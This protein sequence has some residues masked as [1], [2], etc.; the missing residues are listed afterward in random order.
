MI[1]DIEKVWPEWKV[2]K[3]IGKGSFG[4][5]YKAVR[6]DHSLTTEAAIK[7][8][9][10]PQD[11][12]EVD[13]LRSDGMDMNATRTYL[14]GIVD[15]FVNEIQLM[16]SF[17]GIQNIVS[18]EDYKVVERTYEIGWDIFIR[19]E[20][21]TP[22][23]TWVID[24]PMSEADVIRLGIDMC[25]ALEICEK[26]QIIHRDIKP[27]NI[28]INDFGFFKLGDFGIARKLEGT[29][30]GLST[31]GTYNYM[32]P[33][34]ANGSSYDA[35]V[36]IYS[37]GIVLYRLLNSNRLP[38][39]D[40]DQQLMSPAARKEAIERRMRGEALPPPKNASKIMAGLIL[41][42]CAYDPNKRFKNASVMKAAL[43][44]V[45]NNAPAATPRMQ[46]A[47]KTAA[48]P[49]TNATERVVPQHKA[50]GP[51][52]KTVVIPEE[53]RTENTADKKKSKRKEKK[54]GGFV[55]KLIL[56]LVLIA[57]AACAVCFFVPSVSEN[58]IKSSENVPIIGTAIKDASSAAVRE[59]DITQILASA[60]DYA[61]AEDYEK[62]L[63][64]IAAGLAVYPDSNELLAKQNE[65]QT[66]NAAHLKASTLEQ[67]DEYA[68]AGDYKSAL[69][70]IQLAQSKGTTD[71]DYIQ[72]TAEY[73][74]ALKNAALETAKQQE[75][76]GDYLNAYQTIKDAL[77]I[78]GSDTALNV[79]LTLYEQYYVDAVVA[80]ANE[81]I[82]A[83][84]YSGARTILNAA[85]KNLPDNATLTSKLDEISASEPVSLSTF[86][87]ING[88]FEFNNTVPED[89][90][91]NDYS[92][93]VNYVVLGRYNGGDYAEVRV[94]GEYSSITMNVAP[95]KDIGEDATGYVQIYADDVLV[96]TS[97]VITRKTDAVSVS[98][99]ISGA[100]YIKIV[101]QKDYYGSIILSNILLWPN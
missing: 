61:A 50:A 66:E 74:E 94:Y 46:A 2:E 64:E 91:G 63:S 96:Q 44:N 52:Q 42:A 48:R 53:A 93:A 97:P 99:N 34:V 38:F 86:T 67:A 11:T 13:S 36:D 87:A 72:K 80:Q 68:S 19:M 65:Y 24:H 77:D 5:V 23:N 4:V 79:R 73:T 3:Q 54:K 26:R 43:Q 22:F 17:K 10:I 78:V 83:K 8:I 29:Q 25:T 85:I 100:D 101:V 27:E 35:R 41:C 95:Y 62:A 92:D 49:T 20:L 45:A 15:D 82:S 39:I 40:T 58:L 18:V 21:L 84:D 90:F 7:V 81:K 16:E 14:R 37:L 31:K 6:T 51:T 69:K 59:D 33:E 76:N 55:K 47:A 1:S 57:S 28:F 98:A 56:L 71:S 12:S 60:A 88:G 75:Q 30:S 32:A 9:S 89:P 70:T